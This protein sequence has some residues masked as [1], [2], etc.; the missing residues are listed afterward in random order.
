[1][2]RRNLTV[3]NLKKDRNIEGL[4]MLLEDEDHAVREQA[5]LALGEI[6]DTSC[7]L[8][9]A[10][11]MQDAYLDIR[12]A[13]CTAFI[14]MGNQAVEPLIEVLKDQN[15]ILREGA[16][17][18][19]EKIRDP[20]SIYPL[21]EA[22]KDTNRKR[23]ADALK[24]IGSAAF[25]PLIES[26]EN[27]DSR[28]KM[29]AAVTLGEMKNPAALNALAKLVKDNDPLVRQFAKSAIHRIKQ[30]NPKSKKARFR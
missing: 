17:Q 13:A 25:E 19:L 3:E 22:F 23:I 26:L 20:R 12:I 6:G 8:P 7:A 2:E 10:Q 15:R 4:T 18:A 16:A 28:I 27:G 9:L 24:S 30:Q 5:V 29:G 1:M 11:R 21:I 14:K